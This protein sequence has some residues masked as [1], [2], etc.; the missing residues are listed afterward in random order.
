MA[1]GWVSVYRSQIEIHQASQKTYTDLQVQVWMQGIQNRPERAEHLSAVPPGEGSGSK[2]RE[3]KGVFA[4][5]LL[6]TGVLV[7]SCAQIHLLFPSTM[8]KPTAGTFQD[9]ISLS[10]SC[11][12]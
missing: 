3:A 11:L 5:N 10:G 2:R 9:F 4:F 8:V 1:A 7:E 6:N 12:Q